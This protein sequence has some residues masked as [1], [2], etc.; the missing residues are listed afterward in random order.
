MPPCYLEEKNPR[1]SPCM[2]RARG[3]HGGVVGLSVRTGKA[4]SSHSEKNVGSHRSF[5]PPREVDCHKSL[6]D[7]TFCLLSCEPL[8]QVLLTRGGG[9]RLVVGGG[10]PRGG[11]LWSPRGL[12]QVEGW[13]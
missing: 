5:C 7:M 2:L 6:R 13:A 10:R 8:W 4:Q 9:M 11:G 3:A 12:V 1:K